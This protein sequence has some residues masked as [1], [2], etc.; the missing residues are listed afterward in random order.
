[1]S[2]LQSEPI[3]GQLSVKPPSMAWFGPD[4]HICVG[5]E[6]KIT[7][8]VNCQHD[9]YL[10]LCGLSRQSRRYTAVTSFS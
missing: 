3:A 7:S 2:G 9:R 6:L 10:L 4:A 8:S 1:M 5:T